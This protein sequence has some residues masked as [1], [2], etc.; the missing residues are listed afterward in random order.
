[1]KYIQALQS[2]AASL[3]LDTSLIRTPSA[4]A[5]ITMVRE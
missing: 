1:M 5:M 2:L 4:L 3:S